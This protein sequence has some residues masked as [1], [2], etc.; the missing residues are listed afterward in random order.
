MSEE[1][2]IKPEIDD[3]PWGIGQV[4]E[5]ASHQSSES[6]RH[7]SNSFIDI[8]NHLIKT[9]SN[10]SNSTDDDSWQ[11]TSLPNMPPSISISISPQ[12]VGL[13]F[14]HINYIIHVLKL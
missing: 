10:E 3:N 1:L 9:T 5:A 2:S 11:I 8:P 6:T 7:H 14:K 12:K 4:K 13:V